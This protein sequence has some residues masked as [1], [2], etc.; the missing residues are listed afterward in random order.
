VITA[1]LDPEAAE[2]FFMVTAAVV[3]FAADELQSQVDANC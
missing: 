3:A 2:Q 1:A